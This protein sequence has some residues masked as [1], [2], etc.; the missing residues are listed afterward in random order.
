MVV[1]KPV[2][3][4]TLLGINVIVFVLMT[5]AG[6]S[7]SIGVLVE[8]GAKVNSLIIAGQ[9]W[10]L[11]TPMFLHIGFEHLVLNMITLYFVGIQL[12]G[13]LGRVR[14]LAVYLVSGVAGNLAS[15][16]FNPNALSAGAST[17]LF[18][19]FGIYLMMGESFS[20]NPYIRA[21]ARQFLLLVVLN[22]V[23]GFYGSVDLAGH[24]GGLIGG[25]LIGY[26][27]GVPRVGNVPLPKRVVSGLALVCLCIMMFTLGF[28]N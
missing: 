23:F 25:F 5:L 21:M 11:I 13:I 14:F 22:I 20:S 2:V 15:F 19:L 4:Y 9:W 3:T 26:C 28:K 8:F 18:G 10:R 16:A 12:E 6:G 27:V 17:A 7:E 1:K 24:I